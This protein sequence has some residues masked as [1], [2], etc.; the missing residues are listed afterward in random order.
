MSN[1]KTKRQR[2]S[3]PLSQ[4][5]RTCFNCGEDLT[6]KSGHFV[7]PSMGDKGFFICTKKDDK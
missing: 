5:L 1:R 3:T 2:K 4:M 6:G 7:P